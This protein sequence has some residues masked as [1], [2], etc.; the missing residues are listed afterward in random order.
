MG[1][2]T[3]DSESLATII[4]KC[5]FYLKT[6]QDYNSW[7]RCERCK[8]DKTSKFNIMWRSG[9]SMKSLQIMLKLN[10]FTDCFDSVRSTF[11]G[12]NVPKTLRQTQRAPRLLDAKTG[13]NFGDDLI[14]TSI[15][16]LYGGG[17]WYSEAQVT[18]PSSPS[19]LV[20]ELGLQS[21]CR[22]SRF[23]QEHCLKNNGYVDG[24]LSI[25]SIKDL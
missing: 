10:L 17:N 25:C 12:S 21:P 20:T 15:P 4:S 2:D 6:K 13:R 1:L 22:D 8:S 9:W 18:W 3:P 16:P 14:L 5:P 19:L 23:S 11:W 24:R 7:N